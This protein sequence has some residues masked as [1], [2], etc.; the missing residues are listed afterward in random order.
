MAAPRSFQF[1]PAALTRC[2]DLDGLIALK[3]SE[4]AVV[5]VE[6]RHR[7]DLIVCETLDRETV[8]THRHTL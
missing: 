1:S 7:A 4:A 5:A 2:G 6:A 8:T 3:L